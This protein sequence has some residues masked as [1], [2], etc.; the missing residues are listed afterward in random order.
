MNQTIIT[1]IKIPFK[2]QSLIM[3]IG[4][5]CNFAFFVSIVKSQLALYRFVRESQQID[6][7][8][9]V[10]LDIFTTIYF[11]RYNSL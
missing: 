2:L 6:F 7:T 8:S 4:N 9:A 5:L 1:S 10:H 3:T 11:I